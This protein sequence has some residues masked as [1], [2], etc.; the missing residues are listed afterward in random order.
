MV[1]YQKGEAEATTELVRRLSP[2]LLRFLSGPMQTRSQADDML[3]ECWLRVHRA[4]HTYRP[5]NP[6]LPWVFAI[7]RHTRIDVYR[8]R[9]QIEKRE[10]GSDDL[11]AS[12]SKVAVQPSIERFDIW[13]LVAQLPSSQQEVVR[14]LKVTGMSLEEVAGATGSTVG[15][16]KQK[17]HRAYR[18][19]RT[20]LED[21]GG[22]PAR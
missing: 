16:V 20:L 5:E 4:R 14:M 19:L 2:M 10:F 13:R 7:A 11:E 6:L 21:S 22:G 3:Q 12:G 1:G 18:K 9:N 17:A 15:S 8:R